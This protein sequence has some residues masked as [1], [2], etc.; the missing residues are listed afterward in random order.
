MATLEFDPQI[1]RSTTAGQ[2]ANFL[3]YSA[4][5]YLHQGW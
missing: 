5:Q 3:N 1:M 2:I 4:T